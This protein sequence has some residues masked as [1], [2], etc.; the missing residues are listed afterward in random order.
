MI[1]E[2][3]SQ[4]AERDTQLSALEAQGRA[5]SPGAVVDAQ[6]ISEL[7]RVTIHALVLLSELLP[8]PEVLAHSMSLPLDALHAHLSVPEGTAAALDALGTDAA[9]AKACALL[10]HDG[11]AAARAVGDDYAIRVQAALGHLSPDVHRALPSLLEDVFARLAATLDTS[12]MITERAIVLEDSVQR[13]ADT[14]APV[15]PNPDSM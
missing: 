10:C 4:L 9:F 1:K 5:L 6:A 15:T 3:E 12:Q 8:T 11:A 2:L 13:Y 14:S 7:A